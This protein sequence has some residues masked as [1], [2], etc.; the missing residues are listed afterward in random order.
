MKFKILKC[1]SG[2]SECC[3]ITFKTTAEN[4]ICDK[5][6]R[7]INEIESLENEKTSNKDKS[8]KNFWSNLK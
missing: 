1:L 5:C 2:I 3:K 6:T 8:L 7:V 4:R